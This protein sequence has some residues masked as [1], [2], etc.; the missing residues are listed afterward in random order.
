MTS[1]KRILLYGPLL[2]LRK[3]IVYVLITAILL[4]FI[5]YFAANSPLVIKKAADAFAPDYNISY[6]RI[7]GNVVTGIEI[8]DLAYKQES[9]AKHITLKWNPNGLVKKKI[10]VNTLQIEK[11]NVDTIKTLIASFSSSDNNESNKSKSTEPFDFGVNVNHVSLS[12]EPFVEQGIRISR[13]ELDV[14]DITYAS[15]SVGVRALGLQ[16]DTNVTDIVLK[17]SLKK[18]KLKVKKLIIKDVDALALQTLFIPDSNESNVSHESDVAAMAEDTT[19]KDEPVNPLIP[20]WV[21]ID[22]LEVSTLPLV[23]EPVDIKHLK[24]TGRDAV[25]DVQ[26]LLLQ[27]A[28]IDLNS[29]TNLSDIGYKTKVKNNKLIGNVDFKPKKAL[30]KLYELPIRREAIGNIVL[31]L[32]VSEEEVSTDLRI[33]MKQVL[34]AE[35]GAFN[36]D[37]DNLH[38]YVVYDIKEGSMEAKSNIFLTTPYAKDVLI[39]NLFTMNDAIS[40][41]GEIHGK[42]I[43]GV[44]AKFVKPLNNL[45]VKYEGDTKSVKI[46]IKSDNLQGTFI[47]KD[48]KKAELHLETQEAIE[49]R[50]LVELPAELN[51]TKVNVVI[52]APLSFEENA[53]L[54]AYANITSNVVNVDS[55]ISYKDTLKIKSVTQIPKES[56]LRP[57]SKEL[58]WDS[59]TPISTEVELLDNTVKSVLSTG[60][61][62]ANAHYDLNSTKVEGNIILGGL[63]ADISGIVQEKISVDTKINS[64]TSLIESVKGIYTLGDDVPVV[65]GS[66]DISVELTEMKTV[67]LTL[68][69]PEIMYQADRKTEHYVNDIELAVNMEDQK[70]QLDHYTL[71]YA[72]QKLFSTKPSTILFKDEIVS[73][74]P[75]W[76]NDELQVEGK[77]DLKG[78]KGTIDATAKKLH[79]AH[80]IIDL[81]NA[82]DIKTVL[83]GNKTSVNGKIIL[84]GGNIHYDLG[85]KTYASDSDILIVQDMK[86]KEA[87]PFMDNL[88]ASVQIETKKP[89]IYNKGAVNIKAKVDLNVYKAEFSDLMVLG[90]VE[91]LKGGSY[92]FEDKEFILD[93]SHVY[94]TGNPNKPLLDASVKYE[95]LNHLI[96]ITI[97]GSA[98]APNINFSSKPSLTK[99]Q[100][101]SVILFD[102]E[103]GAGTNSGEDMMKM[104]GGAMA[105]S[106]LSDFG[107]QLDHLMLGED[108]SIEVG[109]KLSDDITII[110]VNDEVSRVKI[111][112][113]HGKRTESV[114][115]VNEESQSYDIIYKRDF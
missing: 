41:S 66:A 85:Q 4:G 109:K 20:K 19:S 83:D 87:S 99:E 89:L 56:L 55:N 6:S 53:T 44:D 57:Y 54:V 75:L 61:L 39:T 50:E 97:T 108:D 11:A 25:F 59:L 12:I 77:Y 17:A 18:D 46:D 74:G 100:I 112:Y 34:K 90:S 42:Q 63:N 107:V 47:S 95:S 23:Y 9:L 81:D 93:Q 92:T 14:K 86:E 40:Y 13:L 80:E 62:T 79:I 106:A 65:K 24:L 78:K 103:G 71:T 28:N 60:T 91:I 3:I 69:S 73:I 29:S 96:T 21:E 30:F 67:G 104:M 76:L 26:K 70:V 22:T 15:D 110:Y 45:H 72:G 64:L 98:D 113:E 37:I 31:D 48:F 68:R 8:E 16:V 5:V 88:S 2:W 36:L 101:L 115:E 82:I 27:K 84:L 35:K 10:I 43:I 1:R 105:K 49:L 51:Q 32:N 58:K 114:I 52:D 111:K 94:F 38:S 33:E 7:H 102:S